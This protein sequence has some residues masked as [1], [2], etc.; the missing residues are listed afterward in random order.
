MGGF[1]SPSPFLSLRES[2]NLLFSRPWDIP[3][4]LLSAP[5]HMP[6]NSLPP[7]PLGFRDNGSGV[8]WGGVGDNAWRGHRRPVLQPDPQSY[9]SFPRMRF[10][11]T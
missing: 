7:I 11:C 8:G 4:Y 5:L 2:W 6:I 9:V 3:F 10:A 1:Q